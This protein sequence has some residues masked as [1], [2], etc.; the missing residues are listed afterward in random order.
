[1]VLEA[2]M[3]VDGRVDNPRWG[4][5]FLP[6]LI[7]E[8]RKPTTLSDL[9]QE[10]K[11][12]RAAYRAAIGS[13][14]PDPLP[15]LRLM[16]IEA[17]P[18]TA[19]ELPSFVKERVRPFATA[20]VGH[21]LSASLWRNHIEHLEPSTME[22]FLDDVRSVIGKHDTTN[23]D[24]E[25]ANQANDSTSPSTPVKDEDQEGILTSDEVIQLVDHDVQTREGYEDSAEHESSIELIEDVAQEIDPT[26][27][28]EDEDDELL[29]LLTGPDLNIQ[30][31]ISSISVSHLF[32]KDDWTVVSSL[33]ENEKGE[34][35]VSWI[36][37]AM[38][39]RL[40][41][42]PKERADM[43]SRAIESVIGW[44]DWPPHFRMIVVLTIQHNQRTNPIIDAEGVMLTLLS[45]E[46]KFLVSK[47][48]DA[49]RGTVLSSGM[50]YAPQVMNLST[51]F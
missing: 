13:G 7:L 29:D 34:Q 6:A 24:D 8:Y 41:V 42:N 26:V 21:E 31:S 22:S 19:N 36:E 12:K 37:S 17:E 44:E 16:P 18:C 40:P 50:L 45:M 33:H 35:T 14:E 25:E 38:E 4:K 15:R 5:R 28:G 3:Y 49:H 48:K 27:E 46:G 23:R 1:L 47:F 51:D 20:L 39:D 2:L 9:M 43:L 10:A 32:S 30:V 11:E